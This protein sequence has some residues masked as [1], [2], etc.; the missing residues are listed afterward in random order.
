MNRGKI[1]LASDH[2]GLELKNKLNEHLKS[3]SIDILDVG[4]YEYVKD[5]DYPDFVKI[6]NDIVL[7]QDCMGIYCCASG[8]GV[9]MSANR[10]SGIRAV[11]ITLLEHARLSRLH[12]DANVM[13]FGQNFISFDEAVK[14]IDVFFNTEFEGGRHLRRISKY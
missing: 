4:P 9:S 10:K 1:V 14:A 2:S 6:A 12:E 7:N 13:C 8:I 3:L 5:D 11:N